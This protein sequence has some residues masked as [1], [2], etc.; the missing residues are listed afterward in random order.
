MTPE[1]YSWDFFIAHA[2]P[3]KTAAEKLYDCLTLKSRVFLD[4]RELKLGDDWDIELQ[5]AQQ[6]S[7]VTIVLISS[8]TEA[9]YYQREEIAAAIALARENAEKHRVVPVFMDQEARSNKKVPY[10]LRLKHGVTVSRKL[11]L[12]AVSQQLLDLLSQLAKEVNHGP[13]V[14]ETTDREKEAISSSPAQYDFPEDFIDF[15]DQQ[16]QFKMMLENP[17]VKR[18]MFIQAPGG[19]GKTSLLSIFGF[20]CEQQAVPYCR[21]DSSGQPYDNPHFTLALAICDQLGLS[22]RHLADALQPFSV[23]RPERDIDDPT[24]ISQVLAGVSVTHDSLR[25]PHIKERL[26]NAFHVDLA[27]LVEQKGRV[28]C[29]FDSFERLRS[30]E[31]DW[32][33]DTLLTPVKSG[34]VKGVMIVT[35][36]HRWPKIDKWNWEKNA[37]L[38][39]GLPSMNAEHVKSYAQTQNIKITDEEAKFLSEFSAG[40]PLHMVMMVHNVRA[41]SEGPQ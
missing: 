21:I 38:I 29:L 14:S 36:G 13:E 39:D 20:H 41:R 6:E 25:H 27:E 3:D 1:Q 40:I 4:S 32:L 35:A 18:L 37:H 34:K 2:G 23:Y 16:Q 5:R 15:E 30:E 11:S 8:K 19:R 28:V 24:V 22:P 26:K 31:E 33:L 17:V 10:G 9:A 7:L 12:K